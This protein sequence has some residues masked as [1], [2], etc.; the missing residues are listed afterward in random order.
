MAGTFVTFVP[1]TISVFSFQATLNN[2]LYQIST[3]YN[4]FGQRYYLSVQDLSG[5]Q[6]LYRALV[7]CGPTFQATY[8]WAGGFATATCTA[9]HNVPIGNSINANTSQTGTG[10]DGTYTMFATSATNLSYQIPNPQQTNT[11]NGN[12]NFGWNL[13]EGY[14]PNSYLLFYYNTQQ[15]EY[16]TSL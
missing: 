10:Y 8:T 2:A 11:V 9:N 16:G 1:S 12:I 6:I 15:F 4:I 3:P 5:N 13:I 7:S 14:I